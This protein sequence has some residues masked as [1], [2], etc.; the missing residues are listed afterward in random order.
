MFHYERRL[1]AMMLGYCRRLVADLDDAALTR[2]PAPGVNTPLWILGHLAI[3]ADYGRE[4][5]GLPRAC[6]SEWH[7]AFGPET[8]PGKVPHPAPTKAEL[9][10]AIEAG[11]AAVDLAVTGLS[12]ERL[13]APNPVPF[14]KDRLPTVGDLLAH[15]LTTHDAIHLGQLSAW[16]R[17]SGLPA[18]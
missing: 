3:A 14:L 9:L 10:A 1:Y 17:V 8:D 13:S 18:V 11:H 6:P 5:A 16:R 12:A 2:T 15:L 7:A 4:L